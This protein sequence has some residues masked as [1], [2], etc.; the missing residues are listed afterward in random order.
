MRKSRL[1]VLP[2]RCLTRLGF[3]LLYLACPV[4]GDESRARPSPSEDL[5][6]RRLSAPDNP[7]DEETADHPG[8]Q[9]RPHPRLALLAATCET[10]EHVGK[11]CTY[12]DANCTDIVSGA[13]TP[14][15]VEHDSSFD[16]LLASTDTRMGYSEYTAPQ[17]NI[18]L[19]DF[20]KICE[21]R[22]L[23]LLKPAQKISSNGYQE[24]T[25]VDNGAESF[26]TRP[27]MFR[28]KT[29]FLLKRVTSKSQ[30]R[31]QSLNAADERRVSRKVAILRKYTDSHPDTRR[32]KAM[33]TDARILTLRRAA[34]NIL[35][36]NRRTLRYTR[37][38]A[39]EPRLDIIRAKLTSYD[40]RRERRVSTF[41]SEN[42]RFSR[43]SPHSRISRTNR[44]RD[45]SLPN[46]R[47]LNVITSPK[48]TSPVN[49]YRDA[50]IITSTNK[51][52]NRDSNESRRNFKATNSRNTNVLARSA[53]R[54]SSTN[55]RTSVNIFKVPSL[56]MDTP[57]YERH[58]IKY[59]D[60]GSTKN[61][62]ASARISSD[63]ISTRINSETNTN[64]RSTIF[65]DGLSSRRRS[66]EIRKERSPVRKAA[67]LTQT[68]H[69]IRTFPLARRVSNVFVYRKISR[70][71]FESPRI[72][73]DFHVR[74]R[75][76]REEFRAGKYSSR[77]VSGTRWI[78]RTQ[79]TNRKLSLAL[80]S[81]QTIS[82]ETSLTENNIF[83]TR[84]TR[85]LSLARTSSTRTSVGTISLKRR[86]EEPL[87][88]KRFSRELSLT[89]KNPA[90]ISESRKIYASRYSNIRKR[91]I[92]GISNSRSI[93]IP[94]SSSTVSSAEI[95][96]KRGLVR[97][98]SL[99]RDV[100]VSYS[101]RV[102]SL[103]NEIYSK[104]PEVRSSE[105]GTSVARRFSPDSINKKTIFRTT[106]SNR[107]SFAL[108]ETRRITRE[109]SPARQYSSYVRERNVSILVRR[110][111]SFNTVNSRSRRL[112]IGTTKTSHKIQNKRSSMNISGRNRLASER[113]SIHRMLR[114]DL[115]Y[116][117][118]SLTSTR[119]SNS[120]NRRIS[121]RK[122]DFKQL[123]VAEFTRQ[124]IFTNEY[125][126]GII[127]RKIFM[128][129]R[130]SSTMSKAQKYTRVR[131]ISSATNEKK[132]LIRNIPA[133]RKYSNDDTYT[134][135]TSI[136]RSLSIKLRTEQ[137]RIFKTSLS[138]RYSANNLD[139]ITTKLS[140][141]RTESNFAKYLPDVYRT[142]RKY[143]NS[144][145]RRFNNK[146]SFSNRS[147]LQI[148]NIEDF[149]ARI[150]VMTTTKMTEFDL[151]EHSVHRTT[152]STQVFS[153]QLPSS[154]W[155][156]E[157][158]MKGEYEVL[159]Q[160][161]LPNQM[162]MVKNQ[163]TDALP[164]GRKNVIINY[165]E[166]S[167][168]CIHD[169]LFIRETHPKSHQ[170][171]QIS[172]QNIVDFVS[173]HVSSDKDETTAISPW[174]SNAD[175]ISE[176]FTLAKVPKDISTKEFS[177]E[178]NENAKM[179]VNAETEKGY[180]VISSIRNLLVMPLAVKISNLEF[181]GKVCN[182]ML[183]YKIF[184]EIKEQ[185]SRLNNVQLLKNPF[186]PEEGG[187]KMSTMLP[188]DKTTGPGLA[189]GVLVGAALLLFAATRSK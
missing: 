56:S 175:S 68:R 149:S 15:K 133:Y 110:N 167:N 178:Q 87:A 93:S 2:A 23:P 94:K 28:D 131:R 132:G 90:D 34:R 46:A 141:T 102:S 115:P 114:A 185:F 3:L 142:R 146:P 169:N 166:K 60:K 186:V 26:Q 32:T 171:D 121:R 161:V 179:I 109:F 85:R 77:Y 83:A 184:A 148:N 47:R 153:L 42:R 177:I 119:I 74:R 4:I 19:D 168:L 17:I 158:T 137:Q 151:M 16:R 49:I 160:S 180:S 18:D 10:S 45:T 88:T 31:R 134:R 95:T 24:S 173:R 99:A 84:S 113:L 69:L 126:T 174:H 39:A 76:V 170:A 144:N 22:K 189:D 182:F 59:F 53:S 73:N 1:K 41:S 54:E 125:R 65:R 30:V 108:P 155:L 29:S 183:N 112:A 91:S 64:I 5:L 35:P 162:C 71:L 81:T 127:S 89:R 147:T 116:S 50:R 118:N 52:I 98:V 145:T 188:N 51:R 120:A 36:E 55:R 58:L 43:D 106:I 172:Q 164:L 124:G 128:E 97:S 48:R 165:N 130:L 62:V 9:E 140:K 70:T 63:A 143:E 20:G 122:A 40:S 96:Q 100:R 163:S 82:R 8:C 117:L 38:A 33:R 92:V 159:Y 150:N 21:I 154:Q 176:N 11:H 14:I 78:S 135:R 111:H 37:L 6:S 61:T 101:R 136:D 25:A 129:R 79:P 181:L 123:P 187:I 104:P 103:L 12:M 44:R 105:R 152:F 67:D 156:P 72:S 107:M 86:T 138:R 139:K 157:F 27:R 80:P 7:G 57:L 13:S 75:K 66:T